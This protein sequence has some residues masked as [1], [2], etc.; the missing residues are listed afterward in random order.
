MLPN[1]DEKVKESV[2]KKK[3]FS[4]LNDRHS[5]SQSSNSSVAGSNE[6]TTIQSSFNL[7]N[8]KRGWLESTSVQVTPS[9]SLD[10]R[11]SNN[12]TK[13]T[14]ANIRKPAKDIGMKSNYL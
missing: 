10:T 1:S 4:L 11:K 3:S 5:Y 8:N 12:V 2:I 7:E 13:P 6:T 14:T 9:R